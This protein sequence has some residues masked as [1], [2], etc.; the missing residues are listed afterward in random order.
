MKLD[1]DLTQYTKITSQWAKDLKIRPE[2]MK[3]LEESRGSKLPSLG[4]DFFNLLSKATATKAKI[5]KWDHIKLNNF[6]TAN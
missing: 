2:T 1:H 5:N 4:A 6:S 3:L